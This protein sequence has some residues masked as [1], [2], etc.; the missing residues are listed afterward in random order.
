[1]DAECQI[2]QRQTES[3][4]RRLKVLQGMAGK[5]GESGDDLETL[6]VQVDEIENEVC[7]N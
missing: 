2:L 1:M 3:M 4:A 5:A 7:R 6:K